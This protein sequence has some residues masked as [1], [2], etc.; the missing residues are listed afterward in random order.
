VIVPPTESEEALAENLVFL[1]PGR[2]VDLSGSTF[3]HQ[4]DL[5]WLLTHEALEGLGDDATNGR[6]PI[7]LFEDGRQ[8]PYPHRSHDS[9]AANGGGAFSI[10]DGGLWFST[11]DGTDPNDNKRA[12]ALAIPREVPPR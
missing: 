5:L 10:W 11:S 4:R 3:K 7:F 9:I 2:I 8:L 6:S 1:V 12:Y